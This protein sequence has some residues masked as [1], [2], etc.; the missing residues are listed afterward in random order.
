M[1]GD[2]A[3]LGWAKHCSWI[4]PLNEKTEGKKSHPFRA[5]AFKKGR[6]VAWGMKAFRVSGLAPFGSQRQ[7]FSLDLPAEDSADAEHRVYSILGSRHNA[8]RRK[9]DIQSIEEIDPRTSSEATVIN[10]FRD[11]IAAGG[12]LIQQSEEEEWVFNG[13]IQSGI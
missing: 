9:I 7:K 11:E 5:I 1:Q 13:F 3:H 12:G 2:F 8:K 6:Q 4:S 10:A